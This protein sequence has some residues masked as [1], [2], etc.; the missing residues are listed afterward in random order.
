MI[1]VVCKFIF[2]G[3]YHVCIVLKYFSKKKKNVMQTMQQRLGIHFTK[4]FSGYYLG[5]VL[6]LDV[7]FVAIAAVQ[8]SETGS[9]V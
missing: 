9:S 8:L 1:K 2:F 6:S 3:F 4:L 5:F 7:I